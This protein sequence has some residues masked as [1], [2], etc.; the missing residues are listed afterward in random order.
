MHQTQPQSPDFCLPLCILQSDAS[1]HGIG[2]LSV[3]SGITWHWEIPWDLCLCTSLN[4]LEFL[5]SYITIYMD[6]HVGATPADSCFLSQGDSTSAMG[7]LC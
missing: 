3:M 7:W 5:A 4:A 6:I 1:L 2:G